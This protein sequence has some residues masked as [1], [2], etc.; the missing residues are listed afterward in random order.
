ME[1]VIEIY[2]ELRNT[3]YSLEED[4]QKFADKK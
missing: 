1:R 4:I 2:H 3:F